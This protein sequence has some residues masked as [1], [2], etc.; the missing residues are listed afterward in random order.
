MKKSTPKENHKKDPLL[1]TILDHTHMLIAYLDPKFNF[2][3]VNK[4]Y[5]KADERRTSFYL[6][7][8]HFDLFPNE[9]NEKI[10]KQVVKT[11]KPYFAQ[12]KAFEYAEHP[13]RGTSYWDWSLI[14]IK[15][16]DNSV[17]GLVL[18]LANVTER[19][20][21]EKALRKSEEAL[22]E[23]EQ[24]YRAIFENTGAISVIIEE[25]MIISLVNAEF[26]KIVG[27]SKKEVEWKKSWTELIL[28]KDLEKL[29]KAHEQRRI[30]PDAAP[31]HYEMSI[32]NR[33]G[34]VIDVFVT[35][36]MIPGTGKSVASAVDIS[37]LKR[38]EKA[39]K[40]SEE[41]YR[42]LAENSVDIISVLDENLRRTYVSPSVERVLGYTPE[43]HS[44]Q[45]REHFYTPESLKVFQ[46]TIKERWERLKSG[47]D[48]DRPIKLELEAL[49]KDGSTRWLETRAKPIYDD[50]NNFSGV[51]G[52]SRDITERNQLEKQIKEAHDEL[53]RKVQ[54]CTRDFVMAN[55]QLLKEI[56]ERKRVESIL[57]DAELRYRTVADFTYDWEY[58]IGTDGNLLYVSPSCERITGYKA[59]DF[60]KDPNL[61]N[62]IINKEDQKLWDKHHAGPKRDEAHEF[63]FRIFTKDGED[64]WIEHVC[65]PVTDKKGKFLGYRAS[66]RDITRRKK[67]EEELAS[68]RQSLAE[69]QRIAH[70]GNWDWN[71]VTNELYWS[72]EIY[73]IFG[74][75]PQEFGATYEA[76]LDTVHPDDR[77]LVERSVAEALQEDKPYDI[78][79]RIVLPDGAVKIVHEQAEVI[80]DEAG[81][82]IRMTGT[83]HDITERKKAEEDRRQLREELTHVSRVTT[84]GTLAGALAH[85]I[86]QPLTAIMSNAQ[87]AKR[88]LEEEKLNI[89]ELREI[90][91]DIVNDTSRSSDVVHQLRDFMKKGEI[92]AIPLDINETIKEVVTL[93]QRDAEHRN[94]EIKLDTGEN[95]P[96]VMGEK[97]QLQ[98]VILNLVIN[99]FD[100]MMY[101]EPGSRELMIRTERDKD[102]K[103][104]VAVRDTGIGIE[105]KKLEQ[106]FEP[107]VSTKPEG[108]GLGLSINRYI[109]NAHNGHMWAENNPDHGATIHFTLPTKD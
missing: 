11:G 94:I 6:G 1:Q 55:E 58:W 30:N 75:T 108:M 76:F 96:E 80:R 60:I 81:Q 22:R 91:S 42:M 13:E 79:H 50:K 36:D 45:K 63:Q 101:Q 24:K 37:D 38:A 83:V 14:P 93:T 67:I 84:I 34:K 32:I 77:S 27:Y 5:A 49:H 28:P 82:A 100:A 17:E 15:K 72:D 106:I 41:R 71:I 4:A 47:F 40:E 35:I 29:K 103:I 102:D 70:L 74:L 107:F 78:E 98:Q 68:K 39:L 53:E 61:L 85:E 3:K 65:Q 99:G 21:M 90:L 62:R 105:E 16:R 12:A 88:F 104:H 33:Q 86:N 57:T 54:L 52:I 69:A 51:I 95:L 8:N 73:R 44:K 66:N 59:D 64:L 25:D 43:E 92:E 48:K 87:A 97:V 19:V 31:R 10:F 2:I 26:E 46:A 7:K 20:Q 89:D 109:I 23:S 56:E 9:E 18:T